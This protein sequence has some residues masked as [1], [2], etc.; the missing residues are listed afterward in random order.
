MQCCTRDLI[1]FRPP[2][3][4]F[5]PLALPTDKVEW[6]KCSSHETRMKAPMAFQYYSIFLNPGDPRT[7][8]SRFPSILPCSR[9]AEGG[10]APA[11]SSTIGALC[12]LP[13][14]SIRPHG[15]TIFLMLQ[16]HLAGHRCIQ[17]RGPKRRI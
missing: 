9:S 8:R 4:Q 11:I 6:T 7:P 17:L 1:P 16:Y 2:I 10:L 3:R 15:L 12:N 14:L 13:L 5:T